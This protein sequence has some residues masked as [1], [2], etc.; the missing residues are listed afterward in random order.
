VAIQMRILAQ[1][2]LPRYPRPLPAI[3]LSILH[4]LFLPRALYP[5]YQVALGYPST[6]LPFFSGL[7]GTLDILRILLIL[8]ADQTLWR[9]LPVP[10]ATEPV[11]R[12]AM[13]TVR[14][15]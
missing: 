8:A 14:I 15:E 1:F 3:F 11:M 13:N 9:A 6:K 2:L 12:M 5:Q 10:G 7:A 4:H